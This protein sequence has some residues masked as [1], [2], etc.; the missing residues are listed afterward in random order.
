M[1]NFG[2]NADIYHMLKEGEPAG[3]LLKVR[4][5]ILHCEI[6]EPANRTSPGVEGTDFTPYLRALKAIGY[7]GGIGNISVVKESDLTELNIRN[8][9]FENKEQ[10]LRS[11]RRNDNGN[12]YRIEVHFHSEDPR[13]GLREQSVLSNEEYLELK[14]KLAHLDSYSKNGLWTKKTLLATK[15]NPHL[16][17]IGL[18]KLTGFEKEWLKTNIR[19]LKNLGLTISHAVG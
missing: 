10:L 6:A 19:K 1:P 4:R 12:I 18:S 15:E 9:G 8:A 5:Y 17:A 7:Q 16:K 3:Q 11:L 14:R 13:I 2:I